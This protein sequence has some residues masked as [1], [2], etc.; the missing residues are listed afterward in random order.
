M[1]LHAFNTANIRTFSQLLLKSLKMFLYYSSHWPPS[2]T[3]NR[4]FVVNKRSMLKKIGFKMNS[5]LSLAWLLSELLQP[6]LGA[7]GRGGCWRLGI[8]AV[9]VRL[10]G[11]H[12]KRPKFLTNQL[13]AEDMTKQTH[14]IFLEN[15]SLFITAGRKYKTNL[16]S[17]AVQ[18]NRKGSV[19]TGYMHM[20]RTILH[21]DMQVHC[22]RVKK[23]ALLPPSA[24]S[25]HL[26]SVVT[27]KNIEAHKS[28]M[29]KGT[30]TFV[31][32]FTTTNS[33]K[34]VFGQS[35]SWQ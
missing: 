29:H 28:I 34:H 18:V 10:S 24:L 6:Q 9:W 33:N 21:C 35:A 1:S 25:P 15:F 17:S 5:L 23:S 32:I 16:T 27:R 7:L 20:L 30:W 26:L 13:Q 2:F 22:S 8:W 19:C 3:G 12:F 4:P 14:L 31:N 11:W